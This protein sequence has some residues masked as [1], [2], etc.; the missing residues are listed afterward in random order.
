VGLERHG[1]AGLLRSLAV[2]ANRRGAGL[3]GALYERILAHA[4]RRGVRSF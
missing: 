1:D 4:V 3:G 2:A